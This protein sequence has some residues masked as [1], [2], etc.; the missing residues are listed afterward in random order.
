[1]PDYPPAIP[2]WLERCL[3]TFPLHLWDQILVHLN[4]E[5]VPVL[6]WNAKSEATENVG[7]LQP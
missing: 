4:A 3:P 6:S 1:M 7:E 5:Y 2:P